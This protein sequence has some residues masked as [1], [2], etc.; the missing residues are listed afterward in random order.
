MTPQCAKYQSYLL[1]ER[2]FRGKVR[3]YGDTIQAARLGD[4]ANWAMRL[5]FSH[6]EGC[7]QCLLAELEAA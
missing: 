1:L 7:G 3:L 2:A 4:I 5:R 6:I